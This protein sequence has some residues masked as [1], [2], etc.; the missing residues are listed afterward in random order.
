MNTIYT[1]ITYTAGESGYYDRC[2]D[3]VSGNDSEFQIQ[4]FN[5]KSGIAE[6]LAHARFK[7]T[8]DLIT[9]LVNG[10]DYDESECFLSKEDYAQVQ[11]DIDDIESLSAV[12]LNALNTE[13]ARK[14][15]E[16][17]ARRLREKEEYELRV[18]QKKEAAEKEQLA[19]LLAKYGQDN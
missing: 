5:D 13:A 11:S 17:D 8:E 9:I 6:A 4:Y 15:A 10:V 7:E 12:T 2:G 19:A 1:L 3:W 14:K 18:R 16:E